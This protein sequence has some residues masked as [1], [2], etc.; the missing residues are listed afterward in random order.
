[1]LQRD[2]GTIV[3]SYPALSREFCRG[4]GTAGWK[5]F[6]PSLAQKKK[7][8]SAQSWSDSSLY[9]GTV[10]ILL[11]RLIS[12]GRSTVISADSGRGSSFLPRIRKET[13]LFFA[14]GGHGRTGRPSPYASRHS[15]RTY[16]IQRSPKRPACSKVGLEF[17]ISAGFWKSLFW[18][19]ITGFRLP[20]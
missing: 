14:P 12:C 6:W 5:P 18:L 2:S 7:T 13:L 20:A 4:N 17:R 1:M 15:I 10:Q 9:P 8:I 16:Q 3:K 11:K 19:E